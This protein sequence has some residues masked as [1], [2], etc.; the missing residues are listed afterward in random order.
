MKW[1]SSGY[2]FLIGELAVRQ[3]ERGSGR[4]ARR[5]VSPGR[6]VSGMGPTAPSEAP[7][8]V[9][10]RRTRS[11]GLAPSLSAE[12]PAPQGCPPQC[13]DR[14]PEPYLG[15]VSTLPAI[16]SVVNW[17]CA[18]V[19][20]GDGGRMHLSEQSQQAPRHPCALGGFRSIP[21]PSGTPPLAQT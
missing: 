1:P 9:P 19:R 18:H 17:R 16:I 11:P 15:A 21:S 20:V 2:N 3:R 5:R 12:T 6:G 8:R 10:P 14:A 13:W 7:A 4:A